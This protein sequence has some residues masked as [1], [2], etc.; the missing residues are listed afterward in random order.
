MNG[1][2]YIFDNSWANVENGCEQQVAYGTVPN[3]FGTWFY[4]RGGWCPGMEVAPRTL[5]ITASVTPGTSATIR[6][7]GRLDGEPYV[8]IPATNGGFGA[9]I[10][11]LSWMAIH[12]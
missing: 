5:D 9:S 7:E 6:Y 10:R 11:M 12:R 1:D 4:G 2:E 3:Q 8:P